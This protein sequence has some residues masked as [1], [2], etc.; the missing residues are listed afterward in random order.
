VRVAALSRK[1]WFGGG[2]AALAVVMLTAGVWV[3]AARPA[4]ADVCHE[5]APPT[6]TNY[7]SGHHGVA[8]SRLDCSAEVA[9]YGDEGVARLPGGRTGWVLSYVEEVWRYLKREYGS[10]AVPRELP[11]PIGPG[12]EAFGEPKPLI[13]LL[14]S[15]GN[16]GT[17]GLRFDEFSGYRNTLSI[18][19][20]SWDVGNGI[21]RDVI[22]HEACHVVEGAGQG[23]H[24]SPAFRV[25]GDSKW[26]HFCQYDIYVNTGR[27][28]DAA[29][30]F[31]AWMNDRDN[32][33]PGATGV[34][35]FRDWFFPL[36][37]EGGG[38]AQVMHRFFRLLS[39]Y[40]PARPENGN[41]NL[42]YTR[43]MTLGEYVHFT[44]GAAGRDLSG[45][46]AQTFGAVFDRAQFDKARR[47]FPGITYDRTGCEPAPCEPV[48]LTRPGD[49]GAERVPGT[50]VSP[51]GSQAG[52]EPGHEVPGQD[53][54]LSTSDRGVVAWTPYTTYGVGV[55]VLFDGRLY[56]VRQAHTAVPGWEPPVV[57]AL[58]QAVSEPDADGRAQWVP[59]ADYLAGARVVYAG[60]EYRCVQGHTSL[61]GWDPPAVPALWQPVS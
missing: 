29:R 39:Q 10:C 11:A 52:D 59:N 45:R 33:P 35:W 53:Q 58:W 38:N 56:A 40:F 43:R 3:V 25:W 21:L 26:A 51:G 36:W 55:R 24:E 37:Q 7:I 18:S 6:L 34:A 28:A 23:V 13:V 47:D 50:E 22:S 46:A 48:R 30:I 19:D 44:S 4:S 32:V 42:I 5:D 20:G 49:S 2:V 31:T 17:I 27:A 54:P 8:M 16:G 12:C 57:P 41:R 14:N 61:T 60:V 1:G 15:S 9:V